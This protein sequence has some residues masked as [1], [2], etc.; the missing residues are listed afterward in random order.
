MTFHVFHDFAD[1][2]GG[3]AAVLTTASFIPQAW[4]TW[5]TRHAGGISLGMYCIFT[6]GV[7]LWLAYGLILQAWPI[8]IANVITFLLAA[9]ILAMKLRFG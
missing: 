3:I 6:L 8:I 7:V 5:K 9:F 4:H 1:A 2:I